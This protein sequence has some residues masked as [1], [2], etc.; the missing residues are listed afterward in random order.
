MKCMPRKVGWCSGGHGESRGSQESQLMLFGF[1]L[2]PFGHLVR[3]YAERGSDVDVR[4]HVYL[5]VSQPS[6]EVIER[7]TSP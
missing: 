1:R 4:L 5:A 3:E 6:R 7:L 2:T